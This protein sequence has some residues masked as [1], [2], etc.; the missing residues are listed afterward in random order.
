MRNT[1]N[2]ATQHTYAKWYQ[3]TIYTKQKIDMREGEVIVG[4]DFGVI[5]TY[6]NVA[7]KDK[8]NA[9]I[10]DFVLVLEYIDKEKKRHRDYIDI[11]C[12][13]ILTKDN[14]YFYLRH[15]WHY[16]LT[17]TSHFQP[18]NIIYTWSDGAAKHFKQVYA[19]HFF[20]TFFG[21]YKKH[22]TNHLFASHH[23]H[24][25]WDAHFAHNNTI[26]RHFLR[27]KQGERERAYSTTHRVYI[28][29]SEHSPIQSA[30]Q[31]RDLLISSYHTTV[32]KPTHCNDNPNPSPTH[33]SYNIY[34]LPHIDRDPSLKPNLKTLSK[35]TQKF[36]CFEYDENNH[37]IIY[38]TTLSSQPHTRITQHFVFSS[39]PPKP[40]P[41]KLF[42][43]NKENKKKGQSQ[44]GWSTFLFFC[45]FPYLPPP[46][47]LLCLQI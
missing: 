15:A 24:G 25:L 26:I 8:I 23:G 4:M 13:D 18:F 20:S 3:R 2:R 17:Q 45:S 38:T 22:I 9:C 6:P 44:K 10:T 41:Q 28:N 36:H 47:C 40:K 12:E 34:I 29:P 33:V 30:K 21:T 27:K 5:D 37:S 7:Y 31:V 14:D 1:L 39:T 35:G 11:L 32:T 16:L 43:N 42:H 46:F 19:F